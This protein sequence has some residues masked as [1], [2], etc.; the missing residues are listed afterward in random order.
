MNVSQ[1]TV[2]AYQIE[3][4]NSV[5]STEVIQVGSITLSAI[6][7]GGTITGSQTISSGNVPAQ[8]SSTIPA[9]VISPTY[10]WQSG[11]DS[12]TFSDIAGATQQNYSP[13]AL[14]TTTFFRRKVT[15]AG[16]CEAFSNVV[17]VEVDTVGPSI[18]AVEM[19]DNTTVTIQFSEPVFA[20]ANQSTITTTKFRFTTQT[21]SIT[22]NSPTPSSIAFDV[23]NKINLGVDITGSTNGTQ[24][25]VINI[26]GLLY[27]A[28]G[29]SLPIN[30]IIQTVAFELDDDL[31]GVLNKYDEC[32]ATPF[33]QQAD[34]LGCAESQRDDDEDG[35]SNGIDECPDTNEGEE[36]DEFGCAP[37]QLDEDLDGV[38]NDEDECP[39]T[40]SDETANAQGCS[41]SQIDTDEDGVPDFLDNCPEVANPE[42]TD[43]DGDGKGDVCDP[44]PAIAVIIFELGEDAEPGTYVGEINAVDKDGFPVEVSIDSPE[45]L[46]VLEST[47]IIL[48]G[49][50][51][52]E[53]A[54]EHEI[55]VFAVSERGSSNTFV[56]IPV[57]DVPN[58]T[59]TGNFTITVFDVQNEQLGSKVDYTRYFNDNDKGVGKWKIKKKI[60]GGNDA[61]L[62][63]IEEISF[64]TDKIEDEN[65]GILAFI[66]PPDFENPQDH[67]QDNIYEVEV[68]Y[69]NTEDGELEVPIPTTQFNLTVPENATDAIELQSY[70]AL[71]T[72]DTD[73][74]GVPDVQ[75]NSP[76][77]YN[78]DQTDTDGDGVGDA[79]D[80]ADHD[81][82]W[83]PY[84]TC[85][86]TPLGE[87]V[88]L[89]GCIQ[90][91]LPPTN[92]S[93]SKTEKCRN[94][95]SIGITAVAQ[96]Y[97][98]N[99]A[100]S[101]A[102]TLNDSFAGTTNYTIEN[103][104]GGVYTVCLTVDGYDASEY[105][106][107]FE[108]LIEEPEPLSVYASKTADSETVNFSLKG[109]QVYNITHNGKTVQTDQS[110]YAVK[111]D[112]GNNVI[113]I[114]T[115][116]ECQGIFEQTYFNSASIVL[117]PNPI[118]EMLYVY[119]GGE[120]SD[121]VIS[122]YASNG[123][124]IHTA[125]YSLDAS[126]TVPLE[127]GQLQQGSYVVKAQGNTINTSELLIKE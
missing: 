66:N 89:D 95:N 127:V 6:N 31:D 121:V 88:D 46:F 30:Q 8:L 26:L 94:T 29:N 97:T 96:E 16:G 36:V 23:E 17:K 65:T 115:G 56:T 63:R 1:T 54:I 110:N 41:P 105:Q 9:G 11:T 49:E 78:P 104:S 64:A 57:S 51:D 87:R 14:T 62:F 90:F 35:V 99:V 73:Q 48:N 4:V 32:P 80:D 59:Y 55:Q 45:E 67:N 76:V 109:G 75:D 60:T 53:T 102:T 22:V 5:C 107:C 117:A 116:I 91:Y 86:D 120:D 81:G 7:D 3:S 106:R 70:P 33:G 93:I 83:D 84:D 12:A 25:L 61:G 47:S 37:Y 72:D 98:Y 92:F 2:F 125:R 114:S 20:N 50:L 24:T 113:N 101:G 15:N 34:Q 28:V 42:Q 103:L 68:T 123:V 69:I 122:I 39:D 21:G 19:T 77:N 38:L 118:K 82:V 119:V 71:P 112:K 100:V 74:D 108:V 79:S 124:V 111:L 27:D 10:Q 40:P 52:Y 126:R 85:P 13:T 18:I 58:A 44:D 43:A